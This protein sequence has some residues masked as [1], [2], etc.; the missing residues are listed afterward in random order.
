M[1]EADTTV[2]AD[3]VE[4]GYRA[5]YDRAFR[6]EL[7]A[8]QALHRAMGR[9]L[10]AKWQLEDYLRRADGP[11][12]GPDPR[13]ATDLWRYGGTTMHTTNTGPAGAAPSRLL[14]LPEAIHRWRA[15]HQAPEDARATVRTAR[16]RLR[17]EEA[18]LQAVVNAESEQAVSTSPPEAG[19]NVLFWR[20]AER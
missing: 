2:L 6:L 19:E 9:R 13:E 4:D 7:V 1:R 18:V 11:Q 16:R 15:A 12:P 10:A 3:P 14:D 8:L 5:A 20:R 17:E